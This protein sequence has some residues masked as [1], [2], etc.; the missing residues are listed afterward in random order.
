[1]NTNRRVLQS[2][3]E[4][5]A[6]VKD[7]VYDYMAIPVQHNFVHCLV[8][9]W[10]LGSRVPQSI[11]RDDSDLTRSNHTRAVDLWLANMSKQSAHRRKHVKSVTTLAATAKS[12]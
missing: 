4:G 11:G 10:N 3:R 8:L 1:M 5:S 12:R 6:V 9:I 7:T 2:V